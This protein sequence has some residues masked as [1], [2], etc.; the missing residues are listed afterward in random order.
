MGE[1]RHLKELLPATPFAR[2]LIESSVHL[3]DGTTLL[4]ELPLPTNTDRDVL[5][6]HRQTETLMQ[7]DRDAWWDTD[8]NEFNLDHTPRVVE[9]DPPERANSSGESSTRHRYVGNWD[10]PLYER[11]Q[12]NDA[13]VWKSL[14]DIY[15]TPE[16]EQ[17]GQKDPIIAEEIRS[18]QTT[19][20][21][22]D[23]N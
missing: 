20:G 7:R 18:E 12:F 4:E 17:Y 21:V 19:K 23:P 15:W 9:T 14:H 2:N 10:V 5:S 6:I 3:V 13:G 11:L 1:G 22:S 16:W 8:S